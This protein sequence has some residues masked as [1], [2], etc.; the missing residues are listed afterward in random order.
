MVLGTSE[1]DGEGVPMKM[2]TFTW[3]DTVKAKSPRKKR[4]L[5]KKDENNRKRK[6]YKTLLKCSLLPNLLALQGR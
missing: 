4:D 3:L 5:K 1:K 2:A 6:K